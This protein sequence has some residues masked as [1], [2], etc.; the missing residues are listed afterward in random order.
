MKRSLIATATLLLAASPAW[1]Q[2]VTLAGVADAAVRQVSN[3]GRGSVSSLVSGANATSR[4]IIRGTEDLGGGLSAGFHLEHGLL[5]DAGTQ[6]SATQFWDRR[7]TVSLVSKEWGELRAGRDFVPTYSNWSRYDPFSYVGVGGSNNFIS[8]TPNGPIRA[9]FG[10]GLN[11]TVRSSDS[12]QLLLPSG[13]GGLEGGLML[14][15]GE[16]GTTATGQNKVKGL[17]LGFSGKGFNVSAAAARSENNLTAGH[18]FS[19]QVIAGNYDFGILQLSAAVRQ[20]KWNTA[21][22]TSTLLGAWIPL[23][24]GQLK[25]SLNRV[26]LSGKVGATVIDANDAQQLAVGY[27]HELSKR[28]A[29]YATASRIANKGAATYV[30]PGGAAGLAGGGSSRGIELGLRHNF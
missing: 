30:V 16:G 6:A 4:I 23:G 26:D 21:K 15:A 5:L 14:A 27:V 17:R 20:F 8:A 25:L 12:V 3:T 28:S 9:A 11:T 19:D 22:Q 18:A 29:L 1:S 10:S 24:K 2:N 7:S 13:L